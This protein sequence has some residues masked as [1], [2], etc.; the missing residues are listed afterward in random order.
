L[1]AIKVRHCVL[2]SERYQG[3]TPAVM[4]VIPSSPAAIFSH[5]RAN[6]GGAL[7]VLKA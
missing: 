6:L 7:F 1:V 3:S 5:A 4:S 2:V